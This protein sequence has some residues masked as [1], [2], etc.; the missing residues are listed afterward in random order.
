VCALRIAG[1]G[2]PALAAGDRC[3]TEHAATA[4]DGV[5]LLDAVRQIL[6]GPIVWAPA[7]DGAV[8]VSMRGGTS[9]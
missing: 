4:R 9:A 2:D 6:G 3:F 8:V 7:V 5:L 1:V